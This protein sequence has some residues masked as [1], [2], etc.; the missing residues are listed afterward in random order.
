M[1]DGEPFPWG[2]PVPELSVDEMHFAILAGAL[3][4]SRSMSTNG[5]D[6]K[7][8]GSSIGRHAYWIA[9]TMSHD[10]IKASAAAYR[11]LIVAARV[12]AD[13]RVDAWLTCSE[14][15]TE[16]HPALIEAIA[17]FPLTFGK[18]PPIE[19]VFLLAEKLRA[20]SIS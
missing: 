17:T 15:M 12:F 14:R 18:V 1:A 6:S 9:A 2:K 4:S 16:V 20:R 10:P 11:E 7:A 5:W 8:G 19:H 13:A 3:G